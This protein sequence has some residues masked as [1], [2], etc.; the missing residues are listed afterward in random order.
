MVTLYP[1]TKNDIE[2]LLSENR[3]AN[4]TW[5]IQESIHAREHELRKTHGLGLH[6]HF[7]QGLWKQLVTDD[8]KRAGS[9]DEIDQYQE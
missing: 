7:H 4:R 2:C 3:R 9:G 6:S 5:K 1:T 8:R